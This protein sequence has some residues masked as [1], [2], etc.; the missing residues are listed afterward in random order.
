M[1]NNTGKKYNKPPKEIKKDG[2]FFI[3]EHIDWIVG[4]NKIQDERAHLK[5][6]AIKPYQFATSR[7][8]RIY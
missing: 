6:S 3:D 1:G 7:P 2:F 4:G 8:R 5:P